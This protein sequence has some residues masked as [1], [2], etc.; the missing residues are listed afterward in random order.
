MTILDRLSFNTFENISLYQIQVRHTAY[1]TI[2][3]I[4]SIIIMLFQFLN[5]GIVTSLEL[6]HKPVQKATKGQEVCIKIEPTPG[7]TPKMFGR[8][9]DENDLLMSK[10]GVRC[11]SLPYVY[12]LFYPS[13]IFIV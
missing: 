10:V 9:F 2:L 5:V 3:Y 11:S 13:L 7:D 12:I 1:N 8:H 6:N 4:T